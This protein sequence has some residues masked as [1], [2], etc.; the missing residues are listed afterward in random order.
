M[1]SPNGL[2]LGCPCDLVRGRDG[3]VSVTK[4]INERVLD[5]S[6]WHIARSKKGWVPKEE[7]Y[8]K[9]FLIKSRPKASF[10]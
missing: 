9:Y 3:M 2:S 8:Q 7:Y 10:D 4:A 6:I 5:L 1:T